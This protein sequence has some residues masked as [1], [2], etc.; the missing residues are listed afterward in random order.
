M[1]NLIVEA[2]SNAPLTAIGAGVVYEQWAKNPA[3]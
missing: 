2:E 1:F 3:G